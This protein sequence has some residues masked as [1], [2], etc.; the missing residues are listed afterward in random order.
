MIV[1]CFVVCNCSCHIRC[2]DKLPTCPIPPSQSEPHP[3][4]SAT[5]YII[6]YI[7][8]LLVVWMAFMVWA[9]HWKV[10]CVYLNRVVCVK[11]GQSNTLSSVT[12]SY[13]YIMF[14]LIL[15]PCLLVT[16][17]ISSECIAESSNIALLHTVLPAW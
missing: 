4:L 3:L 2:A 16:Y 8:Y 13:L 17:L 14:K 9:Q 12:L 5:V 10:G 11:A 7:Q 15:Q 6:I 1:S